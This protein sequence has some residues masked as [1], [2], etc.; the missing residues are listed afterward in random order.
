[1]EL[2]HH[3]DL[4]RMITAGRMG[5]REGDVGATWDGKSVTT[6]LAGCVSV[7]RRRRRR[8]DG[9]MTSVQT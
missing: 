5:V 4:R 7:F 2:G 1:M 6:Q 3:V 8:G 9:G